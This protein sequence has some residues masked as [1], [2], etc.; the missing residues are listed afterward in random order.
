VRTVKIFA[1]KMMGTEDVRIDVGLNKYIWHKGIRNVP[2]R[3]RVKL[4]RHVG[5]NEEGD[6]EEV[7]MYTIV[8]NVPVSTFKGLLNEEATIDAEEAAGAEEDEE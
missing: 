7:K 8:K 3:V 5:V 4:E 1:K 6:D 2:R